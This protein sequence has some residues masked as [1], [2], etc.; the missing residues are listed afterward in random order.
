MT[1][2]NSNMCIATNAAIVEQA[3]WAALEMDKLTK[4]MGAAAFA[5]NNQI[6]MGTGRTNNACY[7]CGNSLTTHG[8]GGC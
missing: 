1:T 3:M 8:C 7:M 5:P 6:M 4:D 2:L